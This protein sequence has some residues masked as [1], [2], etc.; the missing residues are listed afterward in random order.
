DPDAVAAAGYTPSYG[1][2]IPDAKKVVQHPAR[3]P[4]LPSRQARAE[5]QPRLSFDDR[6]AAFECPPLSLLSNP[7]TV[8]RHHLSDE[9]LEEN[10]RMLENV[11]D[12]YGVRGEIVSVRPGPVVTM[13]ELEP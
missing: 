7:D 2:P 9:A 11:L 5:A 6:A 8:Q 12:D 10:A 1:V 13:Y 4:I 3:K